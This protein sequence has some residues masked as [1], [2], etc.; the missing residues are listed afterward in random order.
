M[1]L[2]DLK[3]EILTTLKVCKRDE[4]AEQIIADSQKKLTEKKVDREKRYSFW[5]DIYKDLGER[6][7]SLLEDEAK[8][9]VDRIAKVARERIERILEREKEISP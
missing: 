5:Q 3:N 7:F 9:S 1:N 8:S 6:D 4:E 2:D